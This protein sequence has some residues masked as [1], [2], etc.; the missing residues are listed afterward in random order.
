MLWYAQ[1]V[2]GETDALMFVDDGTVLEKVPPTARVR[3][4]QILRVAEAMAT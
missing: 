3:E 1:E 4:S 2:L